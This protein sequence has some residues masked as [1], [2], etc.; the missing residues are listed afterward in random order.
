MHGRL[1]VRTSEE[2]KA[3]KQK[4][5]QKKLVAYH[6]GMNKILSTRNKDS[7]E[8]ESLQISSQILIANPD[9]YTLWNYRKEIILMEIK[10]SKTDEIEGEDKLIPFLED[11]IKFTEQCLPANPKSY[12]VWHH[13]YWILL[14]HPKPNWEKEFSLCTRYLTM[15]DRNF[16]VWDYRRLLVNKIGITL[17][18]ELKFSNERLNVNFSNYSSWHYRSTLRNLDKDC[19]DFEL[20]LVKSAVFTDP[21][22]SSAWFYLRW[23]LSNPSIKK[24]AKEELLDA[25]EQLEELE[26]DCKYIN[27]S[28]NQC[29]MQ[30]G[31]ESAQDQ[32]SEPTINILQNIVISNDDVNN[33]TSSPLPVISPT[34]STQT[35]L[36]LSSHTPRKEGLRSKV[37]EL[38]NEN[39]RL[40]QKINQ[41]ETQVLMQ[42]ADVL[43]SL[44]IEDCQ[45][46]IYKL[47]PKELA[48]FLTIQIA[49]TNKKPRGRRYSDA[50]K[51]ECLKMYF[52]GPRVYKT[53]LMKLF[54]LPNPRTL[55]RYTEEIKIKPGINENIIQMITLK[56]SN[57]SEQDK[58]CVL[59]FDEMAIKA[60]LL[61][62]RGSDEVVGIEDFGC[63]E[64][65]IVPAVS[66]TVLMVRGIMHNWKQPL[67][68]YLHHCS[69]P[70]EKLQVILTETLKSLFRCGLNVCAIISDLGSNNWKFANNM[71]I[72]PENPYFIFKQ[73]FQED[74][75]II[76][77]FDTP[78]LIK[79]ARNN[80]LK[81]HFV[82]TNEANI[83][84]TTSWEH[85]KAFY[86]H[87]IKY[88][89]RAAPKLT[90]AHINPNAFQKMKVKLASQVLSSTVAASLNLYIRFGIIPA[91]AEG[92]SE[93]VQIFDNLFD[94]LNSSSLHHSKKYCQAFKNLEYQKQFL[95]KCDKFFKTVQVVNNKNKV[96]TSRIKCLKGWRITI[97]GVQLLWEKL[98]IAGYTFLLT[99]RLNQDSLENFFGSIRQQTGNNLSPTTFQFQ[100]AF[101]KLLCVDLMNS[102]AENCQG[103]PD[104]VLLKLTDLPLT[105]ND[106]PAATTTIGLANIDLDY[107]KLDIISQNT[108]RY[109]CG[110]YIKKC[111]E[112]HTCSTC[113]NFGKTV[114][115]LDD[116]NLYCFF[117][118]Y[119]TDALDMFGSLQMPDNIFLEYIIKLDKIFEQHFEHIIIKSGVIKNF[120]TLYESVIFVHPCNNFPY[121]YFLNLYARVRLYY[122]LKFIN[123]NFKCQKNIS[124]KSIKNKLI[125]W[126]NK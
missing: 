82:F 35:P 20:D 122:T 49:Q 24:L 123:Q 120:I 93:V 25:F 53:K 30:G 52:T 68:Y 47:C 94:L 14:N 42:K 91:A 79:L 108:A 95:E 114:T 116:S 72:T 50:F 62:N 34:F 1:K 39:Y 73:N 12:G 106:Q 41:L 96:V 78:H 97:R 89:N 80:L 109:V 61:Y 77:M 27:V 100:M 125:V 119:D 92:T 17:D 117:K 112:V 111:L 84:K 48:D 63:G 3:L 57:F 71:N 29:S 104:A 59:C 22:D 76:F 44:S 88:A 23:V 51:Q 126:S 118:A 26:P 43:N 13:R 8:P 10:K 38:R 85:I 4:E 66:A 110:Y 98:K 54:Y 45:Q 7:Y 19:V 16:H 6:L 86:V 69:C 113:S 90:E 60:N 56:V 37:K 58:M 33:Q 64:K 9:V 67:C 70:A 103:D 18:H 99:R 46:L 40:S 5:Q 101:R 81:N 87:D 36:L 2:Q 31:E 32:V 105:L 15:D 75:K 28:R 83:K 55:R 21:A 121:K 124:N 115:E 102:G 107:Q 74:K 11:E 65:S